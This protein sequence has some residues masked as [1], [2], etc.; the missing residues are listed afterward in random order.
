MIMFI[1]M[2]TGNCINANKK[3]QIHILWLLTKNIITHQLI[4]L[5]DNKV[6]LV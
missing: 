3:Q 4:L 5:E 1:K 6:A 2:P